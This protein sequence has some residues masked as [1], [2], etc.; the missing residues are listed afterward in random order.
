MSIFGLL[1][2]IRLYVYYI[3]LLS[4]ID[5]DDD[6]MIALFN[7]RRDAIH[8]GGKKLYE[9]K[10]NPIIAVKKAIFLLQRNLFC[11]FIIVQVKVLITLCNIKRKS[12]TIPCNIFHI[13]M[14]YIKV[15]HVEN[16]SSVMNIAMNVQCKQRME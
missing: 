9:R 3:L 5:D 1:D 7:F 13:V 12:V 15:V 8:F 10:H 16:K 4:F 2:I 11:C 6:D 14:L